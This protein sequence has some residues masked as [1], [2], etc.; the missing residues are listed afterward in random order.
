L[1][2]CRSPI[3]VK[4]VSRKRGP[5]DI[6]HVLAVSKRHAWVC[7]LLAILLLYNPFL[8]AL[9]SAAGLNVDHPASYRATVASS[10]LEQYPSFGCQDAYVFVAHFFGQVISF[11]PDS[12]SQ[13][14]LSQSS[15]LPPPQQILRA[16]LWVRPPPAF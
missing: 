14:F 10:E 3:I 2:R 6:P 9:G 12:T 15:E 13:P 11:L 1:T 8:M 4:S 7:L 5:V 16:S